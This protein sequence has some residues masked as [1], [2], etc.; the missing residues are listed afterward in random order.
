MAG[1]VNDSVL[2]GNHW[3]VNA[4]QSYR[5]RPQSANPRPGLSKLRGA[6]RH[7]LADSDRLPCPEN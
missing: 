6:D 1:A 3:S 2:V 5:P 4:Y 7:N